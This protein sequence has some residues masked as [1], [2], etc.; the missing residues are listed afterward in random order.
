MKRFALKLIS[1]YQRAISPGRPPACRFV[2]SCS[3]YGYEAIEK[4][5]VFRGGLL[6]AKRLCRCHPL[7][8]GGVDLV[9]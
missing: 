8:K 5:G 7:A 4:Y 3:Q 6:V 2:P 9:P 1:F